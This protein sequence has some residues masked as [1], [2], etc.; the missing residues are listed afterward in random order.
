M[1]PKQA[2]VQQIKNLFVLLAFFLCIPQAKI[3]ASDTAANKISISKKIMED[4]RKNKKSKASK[5][6]DLHAITVKI[7]PDVIKRALHVV[8]KTNDEKEM[9]LFVFDVEGNMVVNYKIKSGERKTISGLSKGEYVYHIFCND[10]Q[11][12]TGKMEFR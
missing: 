12:A 3:F 2:I 6:N 7:V 5:K 9:D 4:D 1:K 11:L 10:E 8:T